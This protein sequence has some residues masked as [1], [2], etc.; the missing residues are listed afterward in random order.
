MGDYILEDMWVQAL[1]WECYVMVCRC[2][3]VYVC[4]W[5][6]PVFSG[7]PVTV[8]AFLEWK[9]KFLAEK[10]TGQVQAEDTQGK[11]TGEWSH[12]NFCNVI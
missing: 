3:Y 5:Q 9:K 12:T 8:E 4:V 7:T 2:T 10:N 6:A 1:F 11:L